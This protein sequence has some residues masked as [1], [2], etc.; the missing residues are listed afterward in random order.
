MNTFIY[1][2]LAL[3]AVC[4]VCTVIVMVKVFSRQ[5]NTSDVSSKDFDRLEGKISEENR[6]A[7]QELSDNIDKIRKELSENVGHMRTETVD[8]MGKMREELSGNVGKMREEISGTVNKL[9]SEFTENVSQLRKESSETS[10]NQR[11]ETKK[12]FTDFQTAFGDNVAKL[13]SFQK[14]GF[15][16]MGKRNKEFVGT[17][18]S[19]LENLKDT[20]NTTLTK[21]FEQ[22][23][24]TFDAN[25][26]K[27][28]E[29]QN[30]GFEK[31]EKRQSD[32]IKTT[33]TKLDALRSIVEEKLTTM[34]EK[35]QEGFEKNTEKMVEAQKERFAEMD[36]RQ[37]DLIQTTEKRLDEM[38]A[39][40]DEKLQKTLN[41]RLGQSFK[42][43]SEQLESVQKG[44]GE[45]KNLAS[46]VG[47]LKNALTNVKVRGNFGELQLKALLEQ[48][49]APEQ[50]D[51]NVATVPG[52]S[53][54]VEFAIKL[55]GKDDPHGSVYLPVDSK[56][57]KDVYDQYVD[58]ID[59]GDASAIKSKS[60]QFEN[61]ILAMAKDI[62]TKYLS[63]PDTTNFA[64]MFV[65]VEN[66]YAEVIRRSKL[67]QELRDKW[68]VL[69]TGP[70]TLGALLSSLQMG[71]RTLAIEK[72][73]NDVWT[74]LGAVKTEF[75]KFGD[76]LEKA[77]K[78][79]DSASATIEQLQGTRT[80]AIKRKLREV[81]ALPTDQAASLLPEMNEVDVA[82][83]D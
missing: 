32:L 67:T 72:R 46:D 13:N 29:A 12:A 36:K 64:I 65:P 5:E 63:V 56:F 66:I 23:F 27:S 79:I 45:M 52:S 33:E 40:V 7:R 60:S 58:A 71:F 30:V 49:L 8:N 14:E 47:G 21:S 39:T 57:P 44:L 26:D 70:T 18:E 15:D 76:L 6:S 53:E 31:M 68:N 59:T 28:V 2:I 61:T 19:K 25:T 20:T 1:I 80:K 41:D 75:S 50:Y 55:P 22:F 4:T 82:D 42:L 9:R 81:E 69:V 24:K 17:M 48:M 74:T 37:S 11:E 38:R 10:K 77:K 51:E 3:V 83:D 73:S 35:F 43:V 34:S 62:S 54:R 16:D 78:N